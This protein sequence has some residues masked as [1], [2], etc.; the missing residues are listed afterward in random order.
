VETPVLCFFV[1]GRQVRANAFLDNEAKG[2]T[3][4]LRVKAAR[5]LSVR[6]ATLA[7]QFGPEPANDGRRY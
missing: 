6:F 4:T 1:V 5:M 3:P 2:T 7:D